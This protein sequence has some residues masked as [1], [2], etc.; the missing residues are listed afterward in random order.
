M[1]ITSDGTITGQAQTG[2]TSPTYTTAADG[3]D[4]RSKKYVV[5]GLGGTQTDV[6]AHSVSDPF[7]IIVTRPI[8]PKSLPAANAVTGVYQSVPKN[9]YGFH[10]VKGVQ[11]ASSNQIALAHARLTLDVPAGSDAEDA[12]NL[13]AMVSFLLGFLVEN[14]AGLGDTLAN[15]V[16]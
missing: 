5:T 16:I 3:T 12:A 7:S 11:V 8:A 6:R 15:G 1:S 9:T 13:R 2:F 10:V 4:A 14:S